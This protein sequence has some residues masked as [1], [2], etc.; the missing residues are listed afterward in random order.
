MERT[1]IGSLQEHINE[2]VTIQGWLQTL[3]AQGRA[4]QAHEDTPHLRVARPNQ[5]DLGSA[6]AL[7]RRVLLQILHHLELN[8]TQLVYRSSCFKHVWN[9]GLHA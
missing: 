7:G 6:G 9:M 3:F 8:S 1:P 5:G 2:V 4:I